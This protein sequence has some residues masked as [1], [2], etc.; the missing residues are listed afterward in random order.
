MQQ[1]EVYGVG[2]ASYTV[3]S[4]ADAKAFFVDFLGYEVEASVSESTMGEEY[5]QLEFG[6]R[7]N[8]KFVGYAMLAHPRALP[9]ELWQFSSSLNR[10]D[11]PVPTEPGGHH[12]AFGVSSLGDAMSALS[13]RKDC[14]IIGT[15]KRIHSG[16]DA[17]KYWVYVATCFG[18]VLEFVG[19]LAG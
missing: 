19:P 10:N 15:P 8:T 17:G 1:I 13:Q 5:F 12:L 4:I 6:A 14:R 2:H 9:I 3:S 11:P 16:P 7:P 18:P